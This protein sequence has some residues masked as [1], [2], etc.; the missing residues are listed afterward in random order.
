VGIKAGD[1]NGAL[2]AE[3]DTVTVIEDFKLKGSSTEL[4]RGTVNQECPPHRQ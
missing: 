1:S 2:L 4:E 3:G